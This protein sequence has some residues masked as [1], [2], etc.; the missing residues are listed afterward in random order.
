MRRRV[1]LAT[2]LL[3]GVIF[4]VSMIWRATFSRA[5]TEQATSPPC[6]GQV[7]ETAP[8]ELDFPYCTLRDGFSSTVLLVS[9]LPKPL[10][11]ILAVHSRSGQTLVAPSMTIQPQQKLPIDLAAL[12]ASMG[13]DP[14]GD[15]AEG[16]VS[17]YLNGP[18]MPLAG[19]LT[20]SNP[21]RRLTFESEVVDN[22]PGLGLLPKQLHALWW[23]IAGGRDARIMVSNTSGEAVM[24]DVFLDFLGKRHAGQAPAGIRGTWMTKPTRCCS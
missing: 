23:G 10:D 24:A 8:R 14:T 11:F 20:M 18:M 13:A 7:D 21:A 4:S 16:S 1:F 3:L 2:A 5:Q 22:S 6:C 17:V 12:L 15:F 19:Q 9:D